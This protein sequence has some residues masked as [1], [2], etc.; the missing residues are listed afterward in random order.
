MIRSLSSLENISYE[1]S[2]RPVCSTTIGI[3]NPRILL[4]IEPLLSCNILLEC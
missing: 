2:P 3:V 1:R 4:E